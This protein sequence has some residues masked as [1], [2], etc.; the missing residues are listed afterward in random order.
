MPGDAGDVDVD[1]GRAGTFF[2]AGAARALVE[3]HASNLCAGHDAQVL[4]AP[5]RAQVGVGG[6]GARTAVLRDHRLREPLAP[7]QVRFGHRVAEFARRVE[8]RRRVRPRVA[9]ALDR[10]RAAAAERGVFGVF[11]VLGTQEIRR[12][13]GPRPVVA[14][15]GRPLVVVGGEP[16]HPH[17]RVERRRPAERLAARPVHGAAFQRGLRHRVVV[18]V[19]LAAEELRERGR[20]V[21]FHG[22][23]DRP[24]LEQQHR[25]RGVFAQ[26]RGEGRAGRPRP[27]DDVVG[28]EVG[29]ATDAE[30]RAAAPRTRAARA[31][32]RAHAPNAF[33]RTTDIF[34]QSPSMRNRVNPSH[35]A[36]PVREV[37][38]QGGFGST[39][40]P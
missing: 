37:T 36:A 6:R 18:P 25:D 3:R 9:L 23:V 28:V 35:T 20:H 24:S 13:R 31:L 19:V 33:T 32:R 14:R 16:A 21:Q 1:A 39:D 4:A 8:E 34:A 7:R 11:G 40:S 30:A 26:S 17:H 27:H 29:R 10:L 15:H 22:L 5:R 12:E 2:A 38:N